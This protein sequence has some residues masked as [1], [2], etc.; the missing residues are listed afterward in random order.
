MNTKLVRVGVWS[1]LLGVA[2][3]TACGSDDGKRTTTRPDDGAG[4]PGAA[5][6]AG[7]DAGGSSN[8]EAGAGGTPSGEGGSSSPTSAGEGGMIAGG[9]TSTTAGA[10]TDIAG[11]PGNAGAAGAGNECA[12]VDPE[13]LA[14]FWTTDCNGYTCKINIAASG[15]VSGACTNGQYSSG[16]IDEDGNFDTAG[17]GGP[18]T[19]YTT[20]GK[21]TAT[22][23]GKATWDYVGQIPAVTGPKTNY[24]CQIQQTEPCAPSLLE[25]LAGDWKTTCGNST[26]VTTFTLDGKMT[27][28]CSNGQSSTGTVTETGAFSDEG[29]GGNFADYSTTGVIGLTSC[30]S[31]IMPYTYQ[32]PPHQG[33][34]H[35]QQCAYTR[36]Q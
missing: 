12:A 3:A 13:A 14:G 25:A 1:W 19:N 9:G 26:C 32:T 6:D 11:A 35:S 27:S 18:Y 29:G 23:C 36:Q 21:L 31:F 17:E 22:E 33:T 28:T 8:G 10:P 15:A 16:T 7:R 4:S 34:K 2:V 30:D 20:E 5:G 24:S